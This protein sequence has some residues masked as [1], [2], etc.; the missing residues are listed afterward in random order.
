MPILPIENCYGY[1][2]FCLTLP[3]RC[4]ILLCNAKY[5]TNGGKMDQ[6][7][8]IEELALIRRVME[9][10]RRFAVD[11]GKYYLAWGII[12]TIAI[13]AQYA[14][15]LIDNESVSSWI[16]I[17]TVAFGWLISIVMGMREP[18]K[19]GVWT[20]GARLISLIWV[21]AGVSMTILGFVGGMTGAVHSWAICPVIA[22]VMGGAYT[23]S[24]LVYRMKWLTMVGIAW[25]VGAIVMFAVEGLA[26]LPIFGTMM[27]LFQIVPGLV[28]YRTW[29]RNL[30]SSPLK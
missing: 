23:T 28:F 19:P 1:F 25:W 5:F 22:T 27:I 4:A 10:S 21:S 14:V 8:A 6:K 16:W 2:I 3:F 15:I 9:E 20:V 24:S 13:F 29:K 11:N 17:V 7:S 12:I 30:A 18:S 26:T